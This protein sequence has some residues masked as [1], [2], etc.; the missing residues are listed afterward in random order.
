M[1]MGRLAQWWPNFTEQHPRHAAT[2]TQVRSKLAQ[3][4]T[5]V[6]DDHLPIVITRHAKPGVVMLALEDYQS[7]VETAC[8]MHNPTNASHLLAASTQLA[9]EGGAIAV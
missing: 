6:C 1:G 3:T 5:Q 4:M 8:L 9:G 7:L 2:F